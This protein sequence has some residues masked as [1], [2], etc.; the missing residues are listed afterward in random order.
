MSAQQNTSWLIAVYTDGELIGDLGRYQNPRSVTLAQGLVQVR[1]Y[2]IPAGEKET[3]WEFV[4]GLDEDFT[5]LAIEMVSTSGLIHLQWLG[6]TPTSGSDAT[7]TGTNETWNTMALCPHLP[8]FLGSDAILTNPSA[9][10]HAGDPGPIFHANEVTGKIYRV[11]GYNPGSAA[12]KV[13]LLK[14]V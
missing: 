9:A 11:Q 14:V 5:T 10:N 8:F 6:D 12:V 2:S 7:P 13:R 1:D 3:L 4:A